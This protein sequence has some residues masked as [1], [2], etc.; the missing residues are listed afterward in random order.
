MS[1]HSLKDQLLT[2]KGMHCYY[3]QTGPTDI[4]GHGAR[5]YGVSGLKH[6][7]GRGEI[8]VLQFCSILREQLT[9]MLLQSRGRHNL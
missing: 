2:R 4:H 7:H 5:Q 9:L 6:A 1:A 3:V 8:A